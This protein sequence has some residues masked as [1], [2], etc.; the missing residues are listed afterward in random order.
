MSTLPSPDTALT[1]TVTSCAA[2]TEETV[3]VTIQFCSTCAP[4]VYTGTVPGYT[5]GGPCHGCTPYATVSGSPSS[6]TETDS[7][8]VAETTTTTTATSTSTY[9]RSEYWYRHGYDGSDAY[10]E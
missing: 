1:V 5:P 8:G 6:C 9:Y 3:T 10:V 4:S 7:A 2:A